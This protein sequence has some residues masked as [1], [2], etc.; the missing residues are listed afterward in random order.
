[1]FKKS[2]TDYSQPDP[3]ASNIPRNNPAEP[4]REGATI[5][6]SISIKG[7]L[8]G[9]ED[10]IIQGKVEGKVDLKQNNITVGKNGRV[11]ADIYGK[12]ISVEGEVEGNLHGQEQIIIRSSGNV[13]G[14]ISAPRVTLEDGGKF[15]GSIDMET[16]SAERQR[17]PASAESRTPASIP[18]ASDQVQ[19]PGTPFKT[20][21]TTTRV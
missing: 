9:E 7:D 2:D 14:N 12:L 6:P 20:E 10:L 17:V 16:R 15:K 4:R 21:T 5:G 13:R 11:K 1:M 8:T 18:Q 19:K 3:P